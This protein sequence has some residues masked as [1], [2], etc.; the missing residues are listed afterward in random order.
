MLNDCNDKVNKYNQYYFYIVIFVH[1]FEDYKKN[2]I[3]RCLRSLNLN[4]ED[5]IHIKTKTVGSP[6]VF[7]YKDLKDLIPSEII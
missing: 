4:N 1:H 3:L 5:E 2:D 6:T 7:E